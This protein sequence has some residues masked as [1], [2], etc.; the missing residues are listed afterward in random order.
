MSIAFDQASP[1]RKGQ[2]SPDAADDLLIDSLLRAI[3]GKPP[4]VLHNQA[5]AP[6]VLT[7]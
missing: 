5:D 4:A 7:D 2:L 6:E 3:R 1:C